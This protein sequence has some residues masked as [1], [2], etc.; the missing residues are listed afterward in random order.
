MTVK[1]KLKPYVRGNFG[2][3]D[4]F[5]M[6]EML[7]NYRYRLSSNFVVMRD[8]NDTAFADKP[9][10]FPLSEL[11]E[12]KIFTYDQLKAIFKEKEEDL[13]H[14]RV[15][16]A[17]FNPQ[18]DGRITQKQDYWVKFKAWRYDIDYV[19]PE[20][21]IQ[22]LVSKLP[23]AP[24]IVK[25]SYKG[26]HLIYV[27]N[28]FIERKAVEAYKGYNEKYYLPYMT[29]EILT[30]LLPFYLKESEP[31]LDL[32]AS[33]NI[34][35]IAT[36]F[37][38][39]ELPA[40]KGN[41]RSNLAVCTLED[42][43]RVYSFLT[44][45]TFK[46]DNDLDLNK[47]A[48]KKDLDKVDL[49]KDLINLDSNDGKSTFTIQDIPK[50][51]F[52][53]AISRC[54]VIKVLDEDWE[55]HSYEEWFLMTTL[56]A[57][58]ILYAENEE[59]KEKLIQEFHKKSSGYSNYKEKEAEYMLN[60]IIEYQS[61]G[62]KVHGC[63]RINE[64]I[65]PKYLDAC[66]SCPYKKVDKEGNIYG[67]YL[68]SYLYKENLE[69]DDIEIPNWTLKE[70]GW[71]M[72]DKEVGSYFYVLPYFRIRSHYIVGDL[73]DEFI[74]I[75]DK[76]GRSYI[77]KV[78]RRSDSYKPSVD[79][80]KSFGEI[81]PTEINEAKLFLAKYIEKVK[82][83][84]GVKIDFVGYKYIGNEWD[85][86]VGGNGKYS[87]KEISF[88]FH[89]KEM[90]GPDWYIPEVK[91]SEK[92]FKMTYQALFNLN[93]PPLQIAIAHF[94][95]WIGREFI[96]DR[97]LIG[98]L[99]PVLILLGDTGTG[100]SLRLKLATA[101]Y[102]NPALFSFTNITQASFNN[103][104]PLVKSPFGVDEV[105]MKTALDERKFGELVYNITNIQG[106]MTFNNTYNPIDVPVAITGETEN[107]LIDKAFSNFRGLNRRSIVIELT[108]NW[109]GNSKV[110]D[111]SLNKL[112]FNHGHILNYVRSLKDADK[113]EIEDLITKIEAKLNI[114]NTS[115]NDLRKHL[116]LSLAMFHHF[117]MRYIGISKDEVEKKINSLI[118][119]V[120]AQIYKKQIVKVGET[121]DYMEEIINF[122][123]RV[124]EALN[125]KK[126]LKNLSYEKLCNTIG[127]TPSNR[128]GEILKKFFWKRY[129]YASRTNTLLRFY[130]GV[131]IINP[132]ISEDNPERDPIFKNDIIN[133]DRERL[134]S[135]TEEELKIWADILKL[136]YDNNTIN[137]IVN[138]LGNQRL[139]DVI[140]PKDKNLDV[141]F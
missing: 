28:D 132:I 52:Y 43:V 61:N 15:F 9:K 133:A 60:K 17:F 138:M 64:V 75:V 24:Q 131:L 91:G 27:F 90:E 19:Y 104:F 114:G 137:K 72:Y 118:E 36:R 32:N 7:P 108:E 70:D 50:E 49:N 119:F 79:L 51:E 109:K 68:F 122:I 30:K 95:S 62:L 111:D 37:I 12:N 77:K 53:T 57:I 101:L 41:G 63:K 46:Y 116:A 34:S 83:K 141:P 22:E 18:A 129:S 121:V 102:G 94:L 78:E 20:D 105:I 3:L 136:R 44:K 16:L 59:E 35:L 125:N 89:G 86:I 140:Y 80:V 31:K 65:N 135:L 96:K 82:A 21:Y 115:F 1:T 93:D 126:S 14:L 130:P 85:I 87:R 5:G 139:S 40:Y 103:S 71:V 26:W 128:V 2:M 33:K 10:I 56:Y 127:Y 120:S 84:R 134:N 76:R 25:R 38:S 48:D 112:Q 107:L 29:Y 23:L 6:V 98:Y 110:L 117:F 13:K 55:N 45:K 106:K 47:E 11:F 81:N 4:D 54:G 123:A 113:K 67:H 66:K 69:D 39:D 73:E 97:S 92:L 124:E 74:E 99:N 58:K 8:E 88:I 100:K 42:F